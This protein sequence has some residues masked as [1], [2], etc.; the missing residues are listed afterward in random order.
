VLGWLVGT[1]LMILTDG[2]EFEAA[3]ML[4]QAVHS[5]IGS[6]VR[7]RSLLFTSKAG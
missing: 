4:L 6:L 1:C 5:T 3:G 7:L 2:V